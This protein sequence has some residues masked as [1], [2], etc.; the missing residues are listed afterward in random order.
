MFSVGNTHTQVPDA[1]SHKTGGHFSAGGCS[2]VRLWNLP[3]MRQDHITQGTRSG[4][5]HVIT[6]QNQFVSM[7]MSGRDMTGS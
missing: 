6:E 1:I 5:L 2:F 7:S 3:T 4:D